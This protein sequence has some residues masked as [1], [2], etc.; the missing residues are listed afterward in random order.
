MLFKVLVL[1]LLGA[2]LIGV[3]VDCE[4]ELEVKSLNDIALD[5][6]AKPVELASVD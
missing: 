6:P 4:F 1:L 3:V 5:V 2:A